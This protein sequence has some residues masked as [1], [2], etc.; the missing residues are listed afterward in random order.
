MKKF[1]VEGDVKENKEET[2]EN[3]KQK[4]EIW[5]RRRRNIGGGLWDTMRE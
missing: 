3:K 5:S 1:R 4:E 2:K